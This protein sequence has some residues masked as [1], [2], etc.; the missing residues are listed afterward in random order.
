MVRPVPGFKGSKVADP[1]A[2]MN[3]KFEAQRKED[4]RVVKGIFQDNELRGG[5]VKFP[6]RKWKGDPVVTYELTDGQEYELPL[7]VVRHLNSGC[8]YETH[9]HLLGPDGKHIKNA[10]KVHRFSF[11]SSE[12][13]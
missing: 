5:T 8:A 1:D 6:F 11:K 12:L 13:C 7:G 2:P 3:D 10:K 9:S 4:A